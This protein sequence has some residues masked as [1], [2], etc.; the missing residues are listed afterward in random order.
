MLSPTGRSP[1]RRWWEW[2]LV[3]IGEQ[4][5]ERRARVAVDVQPACRVGGTLGEQLVELALERRA[6]AHEVLAERCVGVVV[7]VEHHRPH[8]F[9]KQ[10]RVHRAEA[11]A[12]RTADRGDLLFAERD[13]Q[14][15]EIVRRLVRAQARQQ[16]TLQLEAP[17]RDL[18][19][20]RLDQRDL[21]GG[22]GG[23]VEI[24]ERVPLL[25]AIDIALAAGATRIPCNDVEPLTQRRRE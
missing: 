6:L 19:P 13:P 20:A 25:D 22:L 8:T 18:L 5:I 14:R 16:V 4:P 2:L 7:T 21:L 1:G 24:L 12:V 3:E 15:L 23:V 9:G 17:R 10:G 11:R